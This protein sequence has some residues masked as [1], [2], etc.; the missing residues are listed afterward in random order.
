MSPRTTRSTRTQ[1]PVA[2]VPAPAPDAERPPLAQVA[3]ESF[4]STQP[5][6]EDIIGRKEA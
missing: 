2:D 1:A 3:L 5:R 4:A 6:P